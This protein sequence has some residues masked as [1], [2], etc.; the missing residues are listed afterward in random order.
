MKFARLWFLVTG[1][2]SAWVQVSTLQ[3]QPTVTN[4]VL[5]LASDGSHV[6]FL[7]EALRTSTR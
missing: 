1:L 2:C 6:E 4:R 3:A 7:P 5:D